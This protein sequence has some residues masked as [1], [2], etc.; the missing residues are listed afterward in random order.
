M[1][2]SCQDGIF[3][4][5]ETNTFMHQNWLK[6]PGKMENNDLENLT[7]KN[8]IIPTRRKPC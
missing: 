3:T 8:N 1:N 2:S 4:K 5:P 7:Y 6:T